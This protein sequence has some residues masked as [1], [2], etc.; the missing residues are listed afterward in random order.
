MEVLTKTELRFRFD[1]ILER[2]TKGAVFIYPT[3]TIY[4]IGCNA[5]NKESVEKIRLLKMGRP[6]APFSIWVPSLDWVQENC[7]VTK[8]AE[9]WLAQLPGPITLILEL[10]NNKAIAENVAPKI[11]TVGIR[12]PD[13]WFGKVVERLGLPIVTSSANKTGEP[14]MTSLE[15]VEPDIEKGIDFMVYEGPKEGKTSKIVHVEQE[16]VRER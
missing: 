12:Y 9:E 4:G 2:I 10:K 5:L 11:K 7:I 15:N 1:E 16:E 8:K 13:H 3:D 6:T 14:F